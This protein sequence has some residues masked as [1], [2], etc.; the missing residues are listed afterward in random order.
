MAGPSGMSTGAAGPWSST[1]CARNCARSSTRRG[2]Q[3]QNRRKPPERRP[4][5][6]QPAAVEFGDVAHDGEPEAASRHRLVQTHPALLDR[7]QAGIV[8]AWPVIV[9]LDGEAAVR[10]LDRQAD[11]APRPFVGIVEQVAE[12]LLE[13]LALAAK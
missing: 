8:E 13:I 4:L 6:R 12:H 2:R 3:R 5:E 10:G 9:D 7:L 1:A 11:P